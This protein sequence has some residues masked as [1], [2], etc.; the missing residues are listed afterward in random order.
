MKI[1]V[2]IDQSEI[3]ALLHDAALD[4]IRRHLEDSFED[5]AGNYCQQLDSQVDAYL[6]TDE[7]SKLIK[8]ALTDSKD[9]LIKA[10]KNRITG[11]FYE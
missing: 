8:Q 9:K 3:T 6:E 11:N 2:E 1:T 7:F 10:V 5:G 4:Y